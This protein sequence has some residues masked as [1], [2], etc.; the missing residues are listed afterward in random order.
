MWFRSK[1]TSETPFTIVQF[2]WWEKTPKSM[3][4][5]CQIHAKSHYPWWEGAMVLL[6]PS[7]Q[8]DS[9]ILRAPCWATNLSRFW[10]NSLSGLV[11][12]EENMWTF[13]CQKI[14]R[15]QRW[16]KQISSKNYWLNLE[17]GEIKPT[18]HTLILRHEFAHMEWVKATGWGE[19]CPSQIYWG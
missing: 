9:L 11:K 6:S 18:I 15:D 19:P 16:L 1:R 2:G 12:S 3:L 13:G 17:S 10:W 7:A 5:P 4:N 8:Q 14:H